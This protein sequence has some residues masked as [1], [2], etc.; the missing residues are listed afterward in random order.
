MQVAMIPADRV[1]V[2]S[3]GR[4]EIEKAGNI[5]LSIDPDGTVSV[6]SEDPVTEWRATDVVKAVGRGFKPGLALNLFRDEYMLVIVDLKAMFDKE[7]QRERMKARV[8]GTK[9]KA[10]KTIEEISGAF[11]SIY[12]NTVGILGK[13]G[14]VTV[15]ERGI[16]ML[17]GGAGHGT[18]YHVLHKEKEKLQTAES[19]GEKKQDSD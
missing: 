5:K 7:K 6:S 18:V 12:E 8:I 14:E 16:L 17:L 19:F 1:G 3:E 2:L 15:A 4:E 13:I 9:G 10:K 11:L